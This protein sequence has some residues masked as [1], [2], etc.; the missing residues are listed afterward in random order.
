[1]AE[2]FGVDAWRVGRVE[3]RAMSDSVRQWA[4]AL[5]PWL[6][7]GRVSNLPTVWSNCLAAWLLGGGG[8]AGTLV[9]VGAAATLV[10]VGGMM[11]NDA[12]DA[13]FDAL[14]RPERPIPMGRISAV[15]AWV[16]S[17]GLLAVG[18]LGFGLVGAE[19]LRF[20]L[21]LVMAV[22]V[23]DL[24]HK[25]VPGAP[26][27]MASCRFFL[28]L[29]AGAATREGITGEIMWSAVALGAYIVGLSYVAR[30]EAVGFIP[31]WWPWLALAVPVVLAG[32]V[33]APSDW[34]HSQVAMP[35]VWYG[36]VLVRAGTQLARG[37]RDG[38]QRAVSTLLAGIVVVDAVALMPT[39][40][41]WGAVF[42][43]LWGAT[44]VFQR[45]VPGT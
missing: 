14:H 8:P 10:Y 23:Y 30:G 1:M 34:S 37:G 4:V 15:D 9:L 35:V 5:R 7:L 6:V 44:L 28:F 33:N 39:P 13:S 45:W 16:V 32:F 19:T 11:L 2:G 18:V 29:A 36:L 20:G 25:G 41:P 31:G 42:V 21:L 26:W 22:V 3:S 24:A 40:W 38:A 12:V 43:G 17:V 27:I